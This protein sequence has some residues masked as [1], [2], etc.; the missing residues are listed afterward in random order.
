MEISQFYQTTQQ[1]GYP[2]KISNG[3]LLF[4]TP[5]IDEQKFINSVIKY[6]KYINAS[7]N[8]MYYND[9]LRDELSNQISNKPPKNLNKYQYW[10]YADKYFQKIT[11]LNRSTYCDNILKN[12]GFEVVSSKIYGNYSYCGNDPAGAL[13]KLLQQ[14]PLF[15]ECLS[16]IHLCNILAFKEQIGGHAFNEYINNRYNGNL[17]TDGTFLPFNIHEYIVDVSSGDKNYKIYE[18]DIKIGDVI[19]ITITNGFAFHGGSEL[20]GYNLL[21]VEKDANNQPLFLGFHSIKHNPYTLSEVGKILEDAFIENLSYKDLLIIYNCMQCAKGAKMLHSDF[22]IANTYKLLGKCNA[23]NILNEEINKAKK[24]E[25]NI[26]KSA[27]KMP[28]DLPHSYLLHKILR[29][30]PNTQGNNIYIESRCNPNNAQLLYITTCIQ[31][32]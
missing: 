26:G 12:T 16:A 2:Q 13:D 11:P 10:Q 5:N 30:I 29:Y 9:Y 18:D 25:N 23:E 22:T 8:I 6:M 1:Q 15:I 4:Q 3:F 28:E 14:K 17:T 7:H 21:C 24:I 19:Y 32:F 31:K 20:N 27:I